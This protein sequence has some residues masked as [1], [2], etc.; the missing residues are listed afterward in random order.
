MNK[1]NYL[2]AK[3]SVSEQLLE[4]LKQ[5]DDIAGQRIKKLLALPDLTRK[6]NSPLKFIVDKAIKMTIDN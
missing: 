5:R 6:E 3:D 2:A 4:E 1:R